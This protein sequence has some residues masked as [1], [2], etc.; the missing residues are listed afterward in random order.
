MVSACGNSGQW[1]QALAL[2]Y[3]ME[4]HRIQGGEGF[5]DASR[6]APENQLIQ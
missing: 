5:W 6:W 2:L 3:Q 1:Q 4:F